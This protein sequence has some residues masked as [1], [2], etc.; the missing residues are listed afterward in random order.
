MSRTDGNDKTSELLRQMTVRP[1]NRMGFYIL[2]GLFGAALG[3]I[4][5]VLNFSLTQHSLGVVRVGFISSFI[6]LGA[7]LVPLI[8]LLRRRAEEAAVEVLWSPDKTTTVRL[9]KRPLTVGGGAD[10]IV[11][12]GAP[13]RVS[14]IVMANGVIEH[15]ETS[16]GARTP[17]KDGSRLRI[18]GLVMVVH[19]SE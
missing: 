2:G 6:G 16:T 18:G 11:L 3:L 9:G 7:V 1:G 10:D 17:L 13:P 5:G 4:I 8:F 19:A 15:I 12:P 14:T